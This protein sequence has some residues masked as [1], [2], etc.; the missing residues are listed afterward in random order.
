MPHLS[1]QRALLGKLSPSLALQSNAAGCA[2]HFVSLQ[3]VAVSLRCRPLL[4]P[5]AQFLLGCMKCRTGRLSHDEDICSSSSSNSNSESWGGRRVLAEITNFGSRRAP[6]YGNQ[7]RASGGD[8]EV[9]VGGA[10]MEIDAALLEALSPGVAGGGTV[11]EVPRV[12]EA[13]PSGI[14]RGTV[15]AAEATSTT[16]TPS[17]SGPQQRSPTLGPTDDEVELALHLEIQRPQQ[18]DQRLHQRR[19]QSTGASTALSQQATEGADEVGP[20]TPPLEDAEVEDAEPQEHQQQHA[21]IVTITD[22]AAVQTD[23]ASANQCRRLWAERGCPTSTCLVCGDV[24]QGCPSPGPRRFG[25]WLQQQQQ[26]QQQLL[27]RA[28]A[29]PIPDDADDP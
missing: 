7:Q 1:C 25:C 14:Q 16:G 3:Q 9:A 28:T 23:A 15:T 20:D 2:V 22:E 21:A 24:I 12:A 27:L 18:Q 10:A 5:L 4:M 29:R 13:L 26:Q 11:E 19:Q 8:A 6:T 17:T